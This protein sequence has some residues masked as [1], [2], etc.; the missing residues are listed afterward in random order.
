MQKTKTKS[1]KITKQGKGQVSKKQKQDKSEK[2]KAKTKRKI[3]IMA[4]GDIHGDIKQVE[5]LAE[6]AEKQ[7]VDLVILTGDITMAESSTAYLIGPFVKRNI[8]VLLIPG[9]HETVATAHFLADLYAPKAK[10]IHGYA[11]RIGDIG[12]FGAGGAVGVGPK[13]IVSEDELFDLLKQGFE[14]VKDAK[15]KLMVTHVHPKGTLMEKLTSKVPASAAVRKAIKE[16][17]PDLLICS[18]AHEAEGIEEKVYKTKV[19]NVG[20][21]GK[22]LELCV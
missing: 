18:H 5:R 12:I 6:L 4:I 8:E 15:F 19:I 17:K 1:T 3:K 20:K 21:R 11:V 10:N 9:N 13:L 22:I 14:K 7:H 2:Q 16:F